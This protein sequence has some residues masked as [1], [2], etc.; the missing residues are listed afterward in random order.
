LFHIGYSRV[1][2]LDFNKTTSGLSNKLTRG[3]RAQEGVRKMWNIPAATCST[4]GSI[5]L[6]ERSWELRT[7]LYFCPRCRANKEQEA[8]RLRVKEE[9]AE[10]GVLKKAA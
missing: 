2:R 4:C 10:L 3:D 9:I 8:A 6:T 5:L 7:E 1:E